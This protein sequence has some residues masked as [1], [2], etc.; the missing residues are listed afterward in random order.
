MPLELK[1]IVV[2]YGKVEVLKCISIDVGERQIVAFIGA[3]GAGKTTT[4]RAISGLKRPTQGEILYNGR[5]LGQVSPEKIVGLGIVHVPEGRRVFSNMTVQEN[6]L[7]GAFLAK[8]KKR[9]SNDLSARY[10]QFPRLAERKNQGA[11]SLSGG[12][13]QMLAIA[14]ALMAQ[15]K[16]MLLDEP[17]MGLS[18]MMVGQVAQM[19][20]RINNQG[21][22]VLLVEQNA[23]VA[24]RL[25][26]KA[27]VLETGSIA[28]EGNSQELREN[29]YV[30]QAYLGG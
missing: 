7:L 5:D 25:A 13:Q 30:K 28:L 17:T 22:A 6:L 19:I 1:R 24:L 8:D 4:L 26:E 20:R 10:M 23:R 18:P 15:P 12:E 21:V 11:G 14:R 27:Y 16:L 9:M 2:H 3:N 29:D